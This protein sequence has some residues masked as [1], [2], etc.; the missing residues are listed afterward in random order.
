MGIFKVIRNMIRKKK[1][2]I[3]YIPAY[4]WFLKRVKH[5]EDG[6][7]T[8][9]P[10]LIYY[11]V[12]SHQLNKHGQVHLHLLLAKEL[13]LKRIEYSWKG[14][15]MVVKKGV[16]KVKEKEMEHQKV[17][18]DREGRRGIT[19]ERSCVPMQL[20]RGHRNQWRSEDKCGRWK[21]LA[22]KGS[23]PP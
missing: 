9:E 14:M 13:S 12:K 3:Q 4:K 10:D 8:T 19:K 1:Y 5:P 6:T 2:P 17:G 15:P 11:D 22:V 18:K 23:P 7:V 21:V 16:R 20:R